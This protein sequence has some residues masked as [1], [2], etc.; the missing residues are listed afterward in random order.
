MTVGATMTRQND[1]VNITG[2]IL[3][4]IYCSHMDATPMEN[5]HPVKFTGEICRGIRWHQMNDNQHN[6]TG[7]TPERSNT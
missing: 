4:G 5:N 7:V 3:G 1:V 2:R 6:P